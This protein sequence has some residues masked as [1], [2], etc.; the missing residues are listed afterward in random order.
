MLDNLFTTSTTYMFIQWLSK[1]NN[2]WS[3]IGT[4]T[5]WIGVKKVQTTLNYEL[6]GVFDLLLAN[7]APILR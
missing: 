3:L 2:R 4:K 7:L 1:I 6:V 5:A